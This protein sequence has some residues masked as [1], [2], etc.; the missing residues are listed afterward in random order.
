MT[1]VI[2]VTV[3]GE[4]LEQENP[5]AKQIYPD[6]LHEAIAASLRDELSA[7]AVVRTAVL[8]DPEH[9]LPSEVLD[10]TDVLVWWSHLS[11]EDVDDAVADRVVQHVLDGMGLLVLHSSHESKPFLR[12][13]G[14]RCSLRWRNDAEREVVWTVAPTHP[15]AEGLPP[16]IVIPEHEMYGEYFDIP[17]PDEL[18]FVSS[19][20]GGEVF[21]S[22]C[23]WTR[24]KGRIFFFGPGHETF[25][26]YH[27]PE[28]KRV[29]AN[30]VCWARRRSSR[31][32]TASS[33]NSPAG[34]FEAV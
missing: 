26:V 11:H 12:L 2:R 24:G 4:G 34:W 7:D 13:M 6:G 21:R 14:T 29:L 16:A 8:A 22:G 23:C 33:S 9:G 17:P 31:V 20:A 15:I 27:Q 3:W 28:V 5:E 30:G 1:S 19:F 25:P 18:V 32:E 10:G